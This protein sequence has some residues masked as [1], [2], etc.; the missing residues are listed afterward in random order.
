MSKVSG[1]VIDVMILSTGMVTI[2]PR[3]GGA[4][5]SYVMD[6]VKMFENDPKL[7]L[8]VVSN[9]YDSI[10]GEQ[11][12]GNISYISPNSPINKFPLSP[13]KSA[14]AH[15][16]GGTLTM[17]AAV[18]YLRHFGDQKRILLHF[19]EEISAFMQSLIQKGNKSIL[20]IHNPPPEL[21]HTVWNRNEAGL[22]RAGSR[23]CLSAANRVDH[24]IVPNPIVSE[25]FVSKGIDERK[26][27]T[28]PLPIDTEQFRPVNTGRKN[29]RS[30][31]FV[32]RLEARKNVMLLLR[33]MN[34]LPPTIS[35]TI[36]GDG[37]LKN[38]IL[39][40][41]A[42]KNLGSKVRVVSRASNTELTRIYQN[43]L[44][45]V[46][47]SLLECYPR[48][49]VE[50]S[51]CGLPVILPHLDIFDHFI[52]AGFVRTFKPNDPLSLQETI[53]DV[54]FDDQLLS[55]LGVKARRFALN[56]CSLEIIRGKLFE[57]YTNVI[58]N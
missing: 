55:E 25:Y 8:H 53:R 13:L 4:V 14:I 28:V 18:R 12:S 41:V 40:Y 5:E 6:I 16:I 38:M 56:N 22:R 37:D 57:I 58:S 39:D 42:S 20:T 49:V 50:A 31:V 9:Y 15:M 43:S 21:S 33:A 24:L 19:N 23:F 1:N 27:S 54:A 48:V 45:L 29:G 34:H 52:N 30:I 47:P 44:L 2:P 7:R 17:M 11:N 46:F 10:A 3:R 35:L 32:G 51:A 36:V 26:V